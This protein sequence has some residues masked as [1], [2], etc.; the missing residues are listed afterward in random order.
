MRLRAAAFGA[1]AAAAVFAPS[2]AGCHAASVAGM[3][4]HSGLIET[5]SGQVDAA[6]GN[7]FTAQY[8]YGEDAIASVVH[9]ADPARTAYLFPHGRHVIAEDY[10][11]TCV[12]ESEDE[13]VVVDDT[14]QSSP[15]EKALDDMGGTG[16]L[17]ARTVIGW[18]AETSA[19]TD[20]D[21]SITSQSTTIA[22]E[23]ATCVAETGTDTQ[24]VAGEY[25]VCI[26]DSGLLGSFDGVVDG[27][28]V[29]ISL[30]SYSR[31]IDD[32]HFDIPDDV[33]DDRS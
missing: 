8:R 21:A 16:F 6:D 23:H 5:L 29:S 30:N 28:D 31:H 9:S 10:A 15:D 11:M 2:V 20:S 12:D 27:E 14:A 25:D 1:L 22:G 24:T 33:T 7:D 4:G 17:S 32:T 19:N 26:T 13:C 18:L 3:D